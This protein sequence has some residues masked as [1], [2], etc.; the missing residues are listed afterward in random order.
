MFSVQSN[1][2]LITSCLSTHLLY[3]NSSK[4]KYMIVTRK[5]SP[6][7]TSLPSLFLNNNHLE[8]V[9]SYKYLG[10]LLCSNLSWS[11][12]IKSACSIIQKSF[13]YQFSPFLSLLILKNS[14]LSIPCSCSSPLMLLF[15][16]LVSSCF[17]W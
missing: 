10:V 2:N 3:V 12:H 6:F 9:Y 15:L 13:R 8:C 17:F 7:L 1:I 5:P 16:C 4:T 11:L 14:S